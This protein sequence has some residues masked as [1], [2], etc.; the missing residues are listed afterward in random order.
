MGRTYADK[1]NSNWGMPIPAVLTRDN[2]DP[3][4]R[5]VDAWTG[6]L[7]RSWF[8]PPRPTILDRDGNVIHSR[9]STV[10]R[11]TMNLH[12]TYKQ[13]VVFYRG[14]PSTVPRSVMFTQPVLSPVWDN[15]NLDLGKS[16]VQPEANVVV[17]ARVKTDDH[18]IQVESDSIYELNLLGLE[19]AI[20]YSPK[21][22][23]G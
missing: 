2:F 10:L 17:P 11:Y 18:Y 5:E 1:S 16:W 15:G 7:Y 23:R 13:Y 21:I 22:Q 9:T 20:Q 14:I 19:Y 3:G 8:I 4:Q 12:R 6:F